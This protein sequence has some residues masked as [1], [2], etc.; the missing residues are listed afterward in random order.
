M[1]YPDFILILFKIFIFSSFEMYPNTHN[2]VQNKQMKKIFIITF[3]IN[4]KLVTN[5][6]IKNNPTAKDIKEM[7]FIFS[8]GIGNTLTENI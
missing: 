1:N 7:I 2:M 5:L 8:Y 6:E 4:E 3:V